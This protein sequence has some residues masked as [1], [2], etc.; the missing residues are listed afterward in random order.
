[1]LAMETTGVDFEARSARWLGRVMVM[2]DGGMEGL[3]PLAKWAFSK[4]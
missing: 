1:M 2:D 4:W 3:L